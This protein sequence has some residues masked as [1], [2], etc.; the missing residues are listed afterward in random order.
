MA[1]GL[2]QKFLRMCKKAGY[3]RI[4]IGVKDSRIFA[5]RGWP[6][7]F[8]NSVFASPNIRD[9]YGWP[10][11]W[12]IAEECGIRGGCGNAQQVQIKTGVLERGKYDLCKI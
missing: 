3:R 11:I 6:F 8:E 12:G 5:C 9:R 7:E 2:T 10:A 4:S 1:S